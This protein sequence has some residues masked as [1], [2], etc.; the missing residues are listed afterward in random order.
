MCSVPS[1]ET[2]PPASDAVLGITE[3]SYIRGFAWT[4]LAAVR[5]LEA[6]KMSY[7][8]TEPVAFG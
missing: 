8:C 2:A 6:E 1:V 5:D 3:E 4:S 7:V